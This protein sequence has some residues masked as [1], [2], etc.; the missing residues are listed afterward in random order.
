MEHAIAHTSTHATAHPAPQRASQSAPKP[1]SR[2]LAKLVRPALSRPWLAALAVGLLISAV[3]VWTWHQL[4]QY[5]ER[6]QQHRF[7]LNRTALAEILKSHMQSY[8]T[9]LRGVASA[10][11]GDGESIRPQV[12]QARWDDI[13][14]QLQLPQLY[15]GISSVAW[16]RYLQDDELDEFVALIR[17]DAR[18]DYRAFPDGRREA[19]QIIEHIGPVTPRTRA[20]WGLDLLTQP[21][22]RDAIMQAV[23]SGQPVLS[24]PMPD[25]YV[26]TPEQPKG[27]GAMMYVPVYQ[28]GRT[29]QTVE[30]RQRLRVGA[31][32]IAFRGDALVS[33]A[34]GTRLRLFRIA[35]HDV[36]TGLSVFNSDTVNPPPPGWQ[37][38]LTGQVDVP[39]Y[40]RT[41]RLTI[42]S[43]PEYEQALLTRSQDLVL[44]M[45]LSTALLMALL[46]GGFVWQRDRQMHASQI[47]EA[48]LRDQAE[49]LILANRYKSE[50]LANMSHEL[51][52]PLNSILILSDQLRQNASGNLND[53]QRRH[54]DIVYR[55]GSD[56]LQ[57]INDVLD[58][59]KVE[60]GR[61]QLTMEP[62]NLQD[63]LVDLDASMRPLAEAKKLQ[64][65]IA[66]VAESSGVPPRVF[67]DRVRLHQILR[68]LLSNA[69][70][71]T[72]QG[73]VHLAVSVGE[74]RQDGSVVLNFS[75]R[76][77]GI[78]IAPEYHP[79]VFEAFRQFDGS[80]KRR[81]GGTGLGLAITRQ[82]AQALDGDIGLQSVPGQGST[83]TVSLPM[84]A[85][86]A[87]PPGE[88]PAP[89]RAG[90][91][92]PLLI[93]EDDANFAA[94]IAD[95]AHAHGFASVH[96][97]TGAQALDLLKNETF[98]AVVLDI[99]LPD[100]SGWQLFRRLRALPSHRH[101]P[102]HI[103]SCL[104]QP[105]GLTEHDTHYLSK[106]LAQ[107]ALEQALASLKDDADSGARGHGNATLLLVED[108][109]AEREHYRQRLSELGFDV[110]A[111]ETASEACAIWNNQK[112][113]V[114]VL[115]MSLP[116]GDGF[117]LLESLESLR[118][119]SGTRVVVNT[120]L[121]VN[122]DGLQ[123]LAG[124]SAVMVR[125][126]GDDT[127]RLGQ[128]VQGFL[129]GIQTATSTPN[130][131]PNRAPVAAAA[132]PAVAA[133][134]DHAN[135]DPASLQGRRLL[136]VDDDIRN[137]YAM[138]ALLDD[139]GLS[140]TTASN[141]EEAIASFLNDP[142]EI[143]LMDMSMPVMDGYVATNL[144]K[145]EHGCT[146]PIIAL[147]AHAMKGDR[148]KCLAAGADD[149]LSKP[150]D[151][152]KLH[153]TL[154][155]WL[156]AAE[157]P[158]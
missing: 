136:L 112:F 113:D 53:K 137:V 80:T 102:V 86:A 78:G 64:L 60:A 81:F 30:A 109:E 52:T 145:T 98:A 95:K 155:R 114:L 130:V 48:K 101:T 97:V 55:A 24:Q 56:L 147:T 117:A 149:Y 120:G 152:D 10:F 13:V 123:R 71:F 100:I 146:L 75:V 61:M 111:C 116:D 63:L 140:I 77:T 18:P 65:Y 66:P 22:Q 119:L 19:Y 115:D 127:D 153:A 43:T 93:V 57:L 70:K 23:D 29:P 144:L 158:A 141:G 126:K 27:T 150:V 108:I 69:I 40:G 67:T 157:T 14:A 143:I 37:P 128:A 154:A 44:L 139:F 47:V 99:L 45:G 129:S 105:D 12:S 79:H 138:S 142:P 20:V 32:N 90:K 134:P 151:R 91:G 36:A 92:Q 31:V 132:V 74:A 94:V 6:E 82:L 87:L 122:Q 35:A 50:F 68:N 38:E 33:G 16:S 54:A 148:E 125:K 26:A 51:R 42:T 15:P 34:F 46:A 104:P 84:Q 118:P 156:A 7:E 89:Q 131:A 39:L 17:A 5:Q 103:I 106:P 107:D 135:A 28:Q 88:I 85:V 58:L 11:A 25:L 8:E 72:D 4:E 133:A 3:V 96:C 76:D 62:L 1:Q 59:A 2:R 9:V 73:Q 121:D 124:Y 41:W 110:T 21:L 49:Q 83:F